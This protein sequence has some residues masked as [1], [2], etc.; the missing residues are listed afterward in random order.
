M[1][2]TLERKYPLQYPADAVKVLNAMSFTKGENVKIV[3]SSSLRSQQYAGDYDAHENVNLHYKTDKLALDYLARQFQFI[4]IKLM[5]MKNVYIGDIKA[6][7]I[8]EW[9]I[10]RYP[11]SIPNLKKENIISKEEASEAE[12][13]IRDNT[14]LGKLRATQELKL[15]I[16][17]WSAKQVLTGKQ[18]LR[19]GRIYTLQEAFSSPSIVKLDVIA[20]VQQKYTEFSIIY[21][22]KNNSTILNKSEQDVEQSLR[23]A[24]I[25]YE[26][27]GNRFKVIK[28]KFSLAKL[29]DNKEDI[30][31]Y[32]NIINSEAGKLYVV[33]SDVKVLGDLL[34]SHKLSSTK[35]RDAI[36]GF[37]HRLSRIYQDDKYLREEPQLLSELLKATK[38]KN[39]LPILRNTETD[40]FNLLNQQTA[41]R[42]GYNFI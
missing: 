31:K 4:I 13:L 16:V 21:E 24:I 10:L 35:I 8:D 39:P 7:V 2:I 27:E 3:G 11:S 36:D 37:K 42:G 20:L 5:S 33:Y 12:R 41:L 40:L 28:R 34:E 15:H 29:K 30:E 17:R 23:D 6:G 18:T 19:D 32:S 26:A 9:N 14:T 22:F 25:L 1:N 38:S